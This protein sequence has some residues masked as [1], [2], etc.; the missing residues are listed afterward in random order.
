MRSCEKEV[1]MRDTHVM[2]E[3]VMAMASKCDG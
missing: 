3:C 1:S 2:R